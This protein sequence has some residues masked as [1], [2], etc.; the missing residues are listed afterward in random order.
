LFQRAS[1]SSADGGWATVTRY[2]AGGYDGATTGTPVRV[3]GHPG[4]IVADAH[5]TFVD[6]RA[7][8]PGVH[9]RAI[10]W[11]Y[12]PG[13]WA[14]AT[15]ASGATSAAVDDQ[16]LLLAQAIRPGR[17]EIRV[18]AKLGYLPAGL[19]GE[20]STTSPRDVS[21]LVSQSGGFGLGDGTPA[22]SPLTSAPWGSAMDL[23]VWAGQRDHP[24][25]SLG[26]PVNARTFTI[27]ADQGCYL[28][29]AGATS[30]LI[31]DRQGHT[32][33]IRIDAGHYGKYSD[34]QLVRIL[35]ELTFAPN[36][37]DPATWFRA[38]SALP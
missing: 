28:A 30:G 32:V 12:A 26:C 24:G 11:Q 13:A 3:N 5:P 8:D 35:A 18:P 7:T 22:A 25:S 38:D 29:D 33:R 16:N 10:V 23:N 2:R 19:T 27:G 21:G 15:G 14:M 6:Y 37:N 1:F 17:T 20:G 36:V 34:A 9:Q 4:V 31:I